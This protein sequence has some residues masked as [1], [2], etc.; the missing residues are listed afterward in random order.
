MTG[1][2][3]YMF[4]ALLVLVAF[5][6]QRAEAQQCPFG[7]GCSPIWSIHIALQESFD[8]GATFTTSTYDGGILI[9]FPM[10]VNGLSLAG[11]QFNFSTTD[12]GA[13]Q[14][15]NFAKTVTAG[16]SSC[17]IIPN[18]VVVPVSYSAGV[19]STSGTVTATAAN[20]CSYRMNATFT[21]NANLGPENYQVDYV[22]PNDKNYV[23]YHNDQVIG[24]SGNLTA[25]L[26]PGDGI[27]TPPGVIL[28][29]RN[30]C[31][32][33]Q[34]LAENT[35]VTLGAA[36][37]GGSCVSDQVILR[38]GSTTYFRF[39]P[40]GAD[41]RPQPDGNDGQIATGDGTV[42]PDGANANL[43]V[44]V[45]PAGGGINSSTVVALL[46]GAASLKSR[47]TGNQIFLNAGGQTSGSVSSPTPTMYGSVLPVSRSVQV[48][49]TATAFASVLNAG[50]ESARGCK[51]IP[52][53]TFVGAFSFQTTDSATNALTGTPNTPVD[54]PVNAIQ[55]FV[56]ALTPTAASAATDLLL[57][58]A[59][60]SAAPVLTIPGVNTLL[61]SAST[62]PVA[63]AIAIGLT[64][65]NDGFARAAIGSTGLFVIASANIGAT[66]ALTARVRFSDA[67][68]PITAT[69]CQTDASTG[70]CL[71]PP[72]TTITATVQ[73]N[74]NTTW[75]A[76][77]RPTATIAADPA[78]HR[79]F[80]EFVD[81]N[82]V[83]RGS[84]STAV[85]TV[86]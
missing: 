60:G 59:C 84:T 77:L 83:V 10:G 62:T 61:T 42:T 19:M 15:V 2:L 1:L 52:P 45:L 56:F 32:V 7:G 75:S 78:T 4:G 14:T 33:G 11:A 25:V 55:S 73:Q 39:V 31:G 36:V 58:F 6:A 5:C 30:S 38:R 69:V 29:I 82:G 17:T 66:A 86:Q 41:A 49:S 34:K 22:T 67:A 46:A 53:A 64:P 68:M 63:D 40:N 76:F 44:S 85:T 65:S 50:T 81:A 43:T 80:F 35:Y 57:T 74:Q 27:V 3:K 18:S 24:S 71:T 16:N 20:T 23:I 54:V 28:A 26:G 48:G 37:A 72:A 9:A 70:Q 51:L 79:A 47:T 12:N 8:N 21:T 13:T